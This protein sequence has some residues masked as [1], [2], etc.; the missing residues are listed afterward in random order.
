M[1]K[2]FINNPKPSDYIIIIPKKINDLS[3]DIILPELENKP[4]HINIS[5]LPSKKNKTILPKLNSP[6]V[7]EINHDNSISMKYINHKLSNNHLQHFLFQKN[8]IKLLHNKIPT[9]IINSILQQ[10]Y[11]FQ[12]NQIEQK[13]PSIY[14]QNYFHHIPEIIP[15]INNYNQN[16]SFQSNTQ[17]QIFSNNFQNTLNTITQIKEFT[18]KNNLNPPSFIKTPLFQIN[19]SHNSISNLNLSQKN[20]E[21][22]IQET[23]KNNNTN[24]INITHTKMEIINKN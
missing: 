16:I 21:L 15:L 19:I 2:H 22:F 7:A 8:I 9:N 23:C 17:F 14:L 6:H 3:I 4:S 5:E 18:S 10:S 13:Y 11:N 20:L 24:L 1:Y 12:P